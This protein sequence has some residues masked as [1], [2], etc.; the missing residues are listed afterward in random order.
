MTTIEITRSDSAARKSRRLRL[1]DEADE[2]AAGHTGDPPTDA[3]RGELDRVGEMPSAAAARSLSRTAIIER[4]RAA[5]LQPRDADEHDARARRGRARSSALRA[6]VEPSSKSAAGSGMTWRG[7]FASAPPSRKTFATQQP[8]RRHD[9][10][11]ERRDRE[12]EPGPPQRG[13]PTTIATTAVTTRRE[14][15]RG[16]EA[17]AFADERGGGHA[18]DADER[19]LPERELTGPAGEHGER[20]RDD[21]VE[22]HAAPR[23]ALRR[24]V[25]EHEREQRDEHDES[26]RRAT[27]SHRTHHTRSSR[28]RD[29]SDPRR[30]RPASAVGFGEAA[31]AAA[32]QAA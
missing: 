27:G 10:E 2:Q 25:E 7:S 18:A 13:A 6:Q 31:A 24:E 22:Q 1:G 11:R 30:E 8:R 32:E 9:R 3:E 20:E 28:G 16:N 19:E 4:A 15:Q 14:D 5:P 17:D 23:F 12:V 29:R 21:R 26:R